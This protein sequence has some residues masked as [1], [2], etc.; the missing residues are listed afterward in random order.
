LA[1]GGEASLADHLDQR[2]HSEAVAVGDQ[3]DS[4][5]HERDTDKLA[6]FHELDDECRREALQPAPETHIP[7]GGGLCLQAAQV[8]D[9]LGNGEV[10]RGQQQLPR[11]RGAVEVSLAQE[12]SHAVRSTTAV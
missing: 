9:R 7:G 10:D 3:V 2:A 4:R 12:S 8:L 1:V 6:C 5:A 11:E